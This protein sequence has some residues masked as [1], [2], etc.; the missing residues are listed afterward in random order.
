MVAP[1]TVNTT[2]KASVIEVDQD[3]EKLDKPTKSG[4]VLTLPPIP[5]TADNKKKNAGP[6]SGAASNRNP[7]NT[8]VAENRV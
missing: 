1:S 5:I 3:L 8:G 6:V 7:S 4:E 2:T